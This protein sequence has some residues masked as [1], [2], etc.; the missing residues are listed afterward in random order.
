MSLCVHVSYVD[1]IQ[2]VLFISSSFLTDSP[3]RQ[4]PFTFLANVITDV[5]IIVITILHV[6]S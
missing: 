1:H 5:V 6:C 4:D 2:W 3:S